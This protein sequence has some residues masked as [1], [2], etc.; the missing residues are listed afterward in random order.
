RTQFHG[1]A[2]LRFR[3]GPIPV[4]EDVDSGQCIVSGSN[5]LVQ[6]QSLHG[7]RLRFGKYLTA[8]GHAEKAQIEIRLREFC[9]S[10]SVSRVEANRLGKQFSALF[11]VRRSQ[12]IPKKLAFETSFIGLR[13][14]RAQGDR[15]QQSWIYHLLD[16]TGY[17]L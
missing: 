7:V 15:R 4:I 14:D 3:G 8:R 12:L 6:F 9:V 13:M 2:A 11:E 1:S 5:G 10:A 16:L 17:A